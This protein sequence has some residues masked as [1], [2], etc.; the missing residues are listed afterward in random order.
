MAVINDHIFSESTRVFQKVKHIWVIFWWS[1]KVEIGAK[2]R[3]NSR[4]SWN[5]SGKQSSSELRGAGLLC[6]LTSALSQQFM[7][8]GDRSS[9]NLL[10]PVSLRDTG[11]SVAACVK[12][13]CVRNPGRKVLHCPWDMSLSSY[14]LRDIFHNDL[15][16]HLKSPFLAFTNEAHR[17]MIVV[18][19]FQSLC[20][21]K[22]RG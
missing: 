19:I 15:L 22:Q 21:L 18:L 1:V 10:V 20:Y 8:L 17:S 13:R 11:C 9:W 7:N 5:V 14:F 16:H 2:A 3:Q 12:V 6:V 4:K